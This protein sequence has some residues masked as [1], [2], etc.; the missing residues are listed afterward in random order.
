LRE[1]ELK[2]QEDAIRIKR[3]ELDNQIALLAK[4]KAALERERN[5][6]AQSLETE[7]PK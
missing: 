1:D 5:A 7:T 6:L 4:Q 2:T 3:I